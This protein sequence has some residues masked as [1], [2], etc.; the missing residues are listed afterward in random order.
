MNTYTELAGQGAR[1]V[2]MSAEAAV[3]KLCRE[4]KL[5]T[6]PEVLARACR[7]PKAEPTGLKKYLVDRLMEMKP[8]A[9]RNSVERNVGNWLNGVSEPNKESA[10]QLCFALK[11]PYQKAEEL[12]YRLCG[13]GFHWRDPQEIV[14][15]YSLLRGQTYGHAQELIESLKKNKLL[16]TP[17]NEQKEVLTGEVRT[18]IESIR[19]D[20][21]LETFFRE[22]ISLLGKMH[23]TAYS[24]AMGF[25]SLLR[26]PEKDDRLRMQGAADAK[27][28]LEQVREKERDRKPQYDDYY[29]KKEEAH[30]DREV[31]FSSSKKMTSR[32][33]LSTYLYDKIVGRTDAVNMDEKQIAALSFEM[34]ANE[35]REVWPEETTFSK[36]INREIDVTRKLLILLFVATDGEQPCKEGEEPAHEDEDDELELTPEEIIEDRNSRMDTML[37]KC[38]FS[39]LDP[40][41]PFDWMILYCICAEDILE[42]DD[43]LRMFLMTLFQR[44]NPDNP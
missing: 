17:K 12:L 32:D 21:E 24:M 36:I 33:I 18:K 38:G 19:S 13:E 42:I 16:K 37:M 8:D 26:Q 31:H 23:N 9:K 2:D 44:P 5:R 34:I 15:L 6:V 3:E 7:L 14:Y 11:L 43:R 29:D 28:F 30:C 4:V 25:L 20:E 40:R 39:P 10:I 41:A 27:E 22:N 1:A 35:I